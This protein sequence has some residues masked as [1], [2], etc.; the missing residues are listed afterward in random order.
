MPSVKCVCVLTG[1]AVVETVNPGT[2]KL[3]E[4]DDHGCRYAGGQAG[5]K[6]P[7]QICSEI[8]KVWLILYGP[9]RHLISINAD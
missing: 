4:H 2:V 6:R 8:S 5:A 1:P 3:E 7:S 9:S